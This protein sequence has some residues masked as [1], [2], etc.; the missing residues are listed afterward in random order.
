MVGFMGKRVEG[1]LFIS[2]KGLKDEVTI[3][4]NGRIMI[5]AKASRI[6]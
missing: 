3:Q 2:S 4:K 6:I 1:I 5:T